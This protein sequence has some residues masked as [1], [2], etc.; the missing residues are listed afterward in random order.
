MM[1]ND[2]DAEDTHARTHTGIYKALH[3]LRNVF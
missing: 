3:P 2:G 1:Q